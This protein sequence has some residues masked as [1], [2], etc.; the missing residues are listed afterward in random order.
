MRANVQQNLALTFA[1]YNLWQQS[2]TVF[3]AL[4]TAA[5]P[6]PILFRTEFI[7]IG[8]HAPLV[9]VRPVG[10]WFRIGFLGH[11]RIICRRL[12][13]FGRLSRRN[14]QLERAAR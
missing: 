14:L 10:A 1:I 2:E 5:S 4:L 13:C 9:L 8:L 11:R 3:E 7:H 12:V 6:I